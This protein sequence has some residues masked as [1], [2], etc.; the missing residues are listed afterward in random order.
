MKLTSEMLFNFLHDNKGLPIR[1]MTVFNYLL[2]A[3]LCGAA[4]VL[5]VLLVRRFLR[6]KLGN[7]AIYFAWLLVAIRLLTPVAFPNPFMNELR[8]TLSV[9]E[10]ARPIAD[11]SRVRFEDAMGDL[12]FA[13]QPDYFKSDDGV[14]YKVARLAQDI[15]AYTSYGWTG[16]WFLFAYLAADGLV[17]C[18]M[19]FQNVRFRRRLKRGR[20]SALEGDELKAYQELCKQRNIKR[21]LPVYYVDPLPSACLVG[22]LRPY[23]ALPLELKPEERAQALAHELC[24][25]K[26]GDEWWGV[27]RNLCC[28]VHWFNPL[29]WV[30]ARFSRVD[31]ELA[32]DDR[33]TKPMTDEERIVY[34]NTLVVA[35]AKRNAPRMSVL[36]TG[37]TMTGKRLKQ[38]I[39]AIVRNQK[40][41]RWVVIVFVALIM[42]VTVLAFGTAEDHSGDYDIKMDKAQY[43]YLLDEPF[44]ASVPEVSPIA[45]MGRLDSENAA[46]SY[47]N[48]LLASPFLSM[49]DEA[50]ER[51]ASRLGDEWRVEAR[52]AWDASNALEL[53]FDAQGTLLHYASRV[54][55]STR[56]Y[57][58]K[59]TDSV[60]DYIDRYVRAFAKAYMGDPEIRDVTMDVQT[61]DLTGR[62]ASGQAL[63]AD[64]NS[65][66]LYTL[67]LSALRMTNVDR[68]LPDSDIFPTRFASSVQHFRN[69][70]TET[71]LYGGLDA[72]AVCAGSFSAEWLEGGNALCVTF[73]APAS[74]FSGEQQ[75]ILWEQYGVRDAYELQRIE[76]LYG[77]RLDYLTKDAYLRRNEPEISE[78]A[79]KEIAFKALAARYDRP[80]SDFSSNV[81]D[82]YSQRAVYEVFFE[83]GKR[84]NSDPWGTVSIDTHTGDILFITDYTR[85]GAERYGTIAQSA[86]PANAES[87]TLRE[88]TDVY[89]DVNGK[90][91]SLGGTLASGTTYTLLQTVLP[92]EQ[93]FESAWANEHAMLKIRYHS[94]EQN[95]ERIGWII[96]PGENAVAGSGEQTPVPTREPTEEPQPEPTP[97]VISLVEKDGVALRFLAYDVTGV[98]PSYGQPS[99]GEIP[100]GE[101]I[102][103]AVQAVCDKYSC[104]RELLANSHVTYA[105]TTDADM[106]NT[107][108][109][110]IVFVN[111]SKNETYSVSVHSPDGEVLDV[112]GPEDGNG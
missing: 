109:W 2:E 6:G 66:F 28:I 70:M 101:A 111:E 10:G 9:D 37:M 75:Q 103:L 60:R 22:V 77:V 24:H 33:V 106:E 80:Q 18:Y 17:L 94:T 65:V 95:A 47:A 76:D 93:A 63:G 84:A 100:V 71:S 110:W 49:L 21:P 25:H 67:D 92:Q 39:S 16:K 89:F 4:L 27:V 96:D 104:G 88:D 78:D 62:Y 51:H 99:D 82:Y 34:A 15:S 98:S 12:A 52:S 72:P 23:I 79:A 86:A 87:Y 50:G 38:R 56:E 7:R 69:D 102:E 30:A 1:S 91:L 58:F 3:T 59:A 42:A 112:Y 35:A 44:G 26:A 61:Y 31:C 48:E 41:Q 73:T 45:V 64:G 57:P 5:I 85:K 40:V 46:I 13:I 36:A 97:G 90:Q 20:V 107:P 53:H 108:Y 54:F 14:S 55:T 29:V 43:G 74:A 8:P 68:V 11:Q 32:C 81:V 83:T 105:Y 19:A